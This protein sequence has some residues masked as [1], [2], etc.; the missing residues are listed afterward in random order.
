MA[1]VLDGDDVWSLTV[2]APHTLVPCAR[3]SVLNVFAG[4][5][6]V[7][8]FSDV[9]QTEAVDRLQHAWRIDRALQLTLIL[10]D[11]E[12]SGETR[13]MAAECVEEFFQYPEVHEFVANRLFSA[14]LPI[15]ADVRGAIL[16][17]QQANA[18]TLASFLE[19]LD[20]HQPQIAQVR[21]AWNDLDLTD[22]GD[23]ASRRRFEVTAIQCGLFR[24]FVEA[25]ALGNLDH[26]LMAGLQD[27]AIK[28]LPHF[29]N[30]LTRWAAPLKEKSKE[31]QPAAED[32]FVDEDVEPRETQATQGRR[33][34]KDRRHAA[35]QKRPTIHDKLQRA[36][37]ELEAVERLLDENKVERATEYARE[38]VDRQLR[39][40]GAEIAVKSLC[41]FAKL[42]KAHDL[43]D[44]QFQSARRAYEVLPTD[45][46]SCNQF[47]DALLC[48]G[49]RDEALRIYEAT[50]R[51]F[52]RDEVARNGQAE[53]LREL[54]Q[55]DEA[56]RL[57]EATAREFP[58]NEVA[59]N[60][61]A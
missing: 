36:Q 55:L 1:L 38:L 12:D 35:R 23:T 28:V 61:Q 43:F 32:E 5:S 11:H 57:Y 56:L 33:S 30:V 18:T 44:L 50:A 14:P 4:A 19:Q 47:A 59:R 53:V 51:E 9:T 27:P 26:A 15:E 58:R 13:I 3:E 39:E 8:S 41:N 24:R 17:A 60:G 7:Q 45:P 40:D 37:S 29:R 34:K 31:E 42:A 48:T 52:P 49:Q 54:G 46:I 16:F 25:K 6:D 20:A 10:L 2:D 22:L 21:V